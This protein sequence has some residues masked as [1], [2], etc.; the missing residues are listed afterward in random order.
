[1]DLLTIALYGAFAAFWVFVL[2]RGYPANLIVVVAI[3]RTLIRY[4]LRGGAPLLPNWTLGLELTQA[5]LRGVGDRFGDGATRPHYALKLRDVSARV[6]DLVGG[7]ACRSHG[8]EIAPVVINGLEHLWLRAQQTSGAKASTARPKSPV[9]G[10]AAAS[11]APRRFV[12]LY[13]HGGGYALNCPRFYVGY[14]NSLRAVIVKELERTYQVETPQVD[15]FLANYRKAP[16][17]KFPAAAQDAAAIYKYLINDQGL[18][19][20]QIVLA[21]DSCG[22]ALALSALL[23][24]RQSQPGLLPLAAALHCPKTSMAKGAS[25]GAATPHCILSPLLGEAFRTAYLKTPDDPASWQ[26]ASPLHCN[27]RDL[28]PVFV[29]T[30]TCDYLHAESLDIVAKVRADGITNWELDVHAD[31]PHTFALLPA[32]VLPYAEVGIA[33]TGQFV[34]R[35]FASTLSSRAKYLK[36]KRASQSAAA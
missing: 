4:A 33:A 11:G 29:Q 21:G 27:L 19:P 35:Q 22:G 12:V 2:H 5:V 8:T 13:Y 6:G 34:A 28:P 31:M 32:F 20:R 14:C 18:S 16:E 15:F 23:R 24:V 1:M 3:Y 9:N 26:D 30:A 36:H 25:D 10:T 17:H 7:F